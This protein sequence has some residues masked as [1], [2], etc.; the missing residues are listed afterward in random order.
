MKK[1]TLMSAVL[2]AAIVASGLLAGQACANPQADESGN[3]PSYHSLSPEKQKQYDAIVKEFKEKTQVLRDK[4][5]AKQIEIDTF[6]RSTNPNPEAVARVAQEI[7]SLRKELRNERRAMAERISKETG[8][9]LPVRHDRPGHYRGHGPDSDYGYWGHGPR[10]MRH[11]MPD[12]GPC[13]MWRGFHP[14]YGHRGP[15]GSL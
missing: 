7:V 13:P 5:Q 3:R 14:G 10:M 4:L 6:A 2:A 9:K 11:G 12:E 1:K 15:C 8:L